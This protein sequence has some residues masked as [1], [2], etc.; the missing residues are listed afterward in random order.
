MLKLAASRLSSSVPLASIRSERSPVFVT[1]SVAPVRRRTGASAVR[2]TARPSA[3]ASG[4]SDRRDDEQVG[5]DPG[6]G[7]VD[8]GER[9][10]DLHGEALRVRHGDHAHVDAGDVRVATGT[11][12]GCRCATSRTSSVTGSSTVSSGGRI[13]S[14]SALT[15]WK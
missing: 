9:A 11:R 2:A 13:V 4:D 15:T 3:A 14:P 12:L 7:V 6:K 1:F 5:A 10:G 8:L